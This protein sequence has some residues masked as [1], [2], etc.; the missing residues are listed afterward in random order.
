MN[1]QKELQEYG[2][3]MD[4]EVQR[5]VD[6]QI[7]RQEDGYIERER[8]ENG[9][10]DIEIGKWVHMQRDRKMDTQI[11]RQ[12]NGYIDREVGKWIHKQR[13]RKREYMQPPCQWE[14]PADRLGISNYRSQLNFNT[15]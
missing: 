15:S 12:E 2:Y 8:Q 6:I 13:Y 14:L 7:E 11:E 5:Q 3:C 9:Y 1:K 10:K 4:R